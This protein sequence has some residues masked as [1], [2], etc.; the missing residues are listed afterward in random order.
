MP[1]LAKHSRTPLQEKILIALSLLSC[2]VG[3]GGFA[4]T[5]IQRIVGG[6]WTEYRQKQLEKLR[7]DKLVIEY[8]TSG[9]FGRSY[10]ELTQTAI[11]SLSMEYDI[12]KL[13]HYNPRKEGVK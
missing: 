2:T 7:D 4:T 10:Y 8:K 3:E 13:E 11:M 5:A 9:M 1:R 6:R 12:K